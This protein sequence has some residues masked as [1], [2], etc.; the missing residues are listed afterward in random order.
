MT[1][2]TTSGTSPT[3]LVFQELMVFYSKFTHDTHKADTFFEKMLAQMKH[4]KNFRAENILDY[5]ALLLA[6]RESYRK[7]VEVFTRLNQV[8][9]SSEQIYTE[10]DRSRFEDRLWTMLVERVYANS[11]SKQLEQLVEA[12]LESGLASRTPPRFPNLV[13]AKHIETYKLDAA[14]DYYRKY[15]NTYRVSLLEV[16]LLQAFLR[17]AAQG[18]IKWTRVKEVLDTVSSTYDQMLAQ[19]LIF[20]AHILNGDFKQ[21]YFVF[22]RRLD[23]KFDL[24]LLERLNVEFQ[25]SPLVLKKKSSTNLRNIIK[26]NLTYGNNEKKMDLDKKIREILK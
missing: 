11:S 21:A 10:T 23:F 6:R 2:S 17:R 22:S 18:E 5:V 15:L 9:A 25:S 12:V 1:S 26:F 20:Y 3:P 14:F 19:N 16:N 13:M 24:D 8:A 4:D 7:I